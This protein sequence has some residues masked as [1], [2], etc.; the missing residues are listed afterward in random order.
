M[1]AFDR[2]KTRLTNLNAGGR[3]ARGWVND[4]GVHASNPVI[5]SSAAL[6]IFPTRNADKFVA[7][8]DVDPATG[9]LTERVAF[10]N[11]GL[12][13]ISNGLSVIPAGG[14]T[15]AISNFEART[16][17]HFSLASFDP[18][19]LAATEIGTDFESGLHSIGGVYINGI[20]Y[21]FSVDRIGI[22]TNQDWLSY[23][24]NP[25]TG[26]WTRIRRVTISR[27]P[28]GGSGIGGTELNGVAYFVLEENSTIG[29][30]GSRLR[31]YS[32]STANGVMTRIGPGVAINAGLG[33]GMATLNS[34][35]YCAFVFTTGVQIYRVTTAGVFT[36]VGPENELTGI[37]GLGM[38]VV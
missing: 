1:P 38:A 34:D 31:L 8:Y 20:I 12:N 37:N 4:T 24:I 14:T 25:T 10:R 2:D 18:Q 7:R 21:A 16:A 27:A 33:V 5:Y 9:A 17:P 29:G 22:S 30:P 11:I 23:R 32:M 15:Y 36:A 35:L 3:I 26:A 19:T 28:Y 13:R 6:A